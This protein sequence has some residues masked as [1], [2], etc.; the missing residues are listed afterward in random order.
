MAKT[1]TRTFKVFKYDILKLAKGD[2]GSSKIETVESVKLI[3]KLGDRKI[4]SYMK[5]H[6][7]KSMGYVMALT[8]EEDRTYA[9]PVETFLEH[10]TEV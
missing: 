3:E 7:G 8:G 6:Y 5:E 1:I 2:D 4:S 10:A 9:M